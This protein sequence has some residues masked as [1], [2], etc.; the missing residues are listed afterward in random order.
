M[1]GNI[2][3]CCKM[4]L[5]QIYVCVTKI[6]FVVSEKKRFFFNYENIILT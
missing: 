3:C 5:L 2:S 1:P 6:C 4:E